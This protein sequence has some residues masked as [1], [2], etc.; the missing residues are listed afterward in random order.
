MAVAKTALS[1]SE[2]FRDKTY[3]ILPFD[4]KADLSR[5]AFLPVYCWSTG[6]MIHTQGVELKTHILRNR[7]ECLSRV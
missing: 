4:H 3:G 5:M 6:F 2:Y 1:F 7:E